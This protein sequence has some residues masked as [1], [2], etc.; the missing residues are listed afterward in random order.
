MGQVKV[1]EVNLERGRPTVEAAVREMVNQL[2]TCKGQGY[3]GVILIHGYG[4]SGVGGG[5]R[6]AVRAKL[7]ERSLAGLV[8]SFCGGEE[9]TER[10]GQMIELCGQ[11]RDFESRVKGNPGVTVVLLK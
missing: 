11:L 4:S 9:W 6:P 8:R 1:K 2:G 5:I 3:K 10:R 7:K